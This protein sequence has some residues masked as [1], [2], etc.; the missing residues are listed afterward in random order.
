MEENN[1]KQAEADRAFN[2]SLAAQSP[3]NA[4][5][6]SMSPRPLTPGNHSN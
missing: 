1:Q 6:N 2:E 5:E 3:A 4:G